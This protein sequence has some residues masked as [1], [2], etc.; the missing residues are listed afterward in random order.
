MT[1]ST[2]AER[3]ARVW[4]ECWNEGTPD[5]IPLADTF[6]HTSPFGRLEGRDF[7][8]DWMQNTTG[9]ST[10]KLTI[11]RVMG[12]GN[13]AVIHFEMQTPDGPVSVCDWVVVEDGRIVAID[14]FYDATSLR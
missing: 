8:L 4:I 1:D 2:D 7:Y 10:A 12:K 13:E 9:G 5:Q 11:L 6:T 3:L 14:S